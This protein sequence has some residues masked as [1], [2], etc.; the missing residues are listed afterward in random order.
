M[1][2]IIHWSIPAKNYDLDAVQE[3][4]QLRW[5]L[6]R[7]IE[8]MEDGE[9]LLFDGHIHECNKILIRANGVPG[10]VPRGEEAMADYSRF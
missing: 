2:I 9:G 6:S 7:L 1:Q 3:V 8:L 5:A 4:H 10:V